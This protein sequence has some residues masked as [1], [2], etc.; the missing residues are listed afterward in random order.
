MEAVERPIELTLDYCGYLGKPGMYPS[1]FMTDR[2]NHLRGVGVGETTVSPYQWSSQPVSTN[3]R[4]QIG[5]GLG[6]VCVSLA[7]I[8]V[9]VIPTHV[10]LVLSRLPWR[11]GPTSM[12]DETAL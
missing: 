4:A 6:P 3:T 12:L 9:P 2:I 5:K 10:F 1:I 8:L 7:V 11:P